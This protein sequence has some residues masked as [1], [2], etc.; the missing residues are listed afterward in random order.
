MELQEGSFTLGPKT[1]I[2]V[3]AKSR[4]V[5]EYLAEFLRVPTG[6]AFEVRQA[7]TSSDT[8]DRI[9]LRTV[10]EKQLGPEGYKLTVLAD[11]LLIEAPAEAGVFYGTQ[12]LRQLLPAAVES[13]N[14]TVGVTWKVPC[15]RIEDKPRYRWRG[16]MLDPGH[17]FLDKEITKRY[18]DTMACYKMNRLHW[19]LTDMGWAIEIKKYPELTDLANRTPIT[20]RWRRAYGKC[21]HGFYTQDDVRELV[22]YAARRQVTIIPEIEM[23][24][25]S[26]AA[27][28]CY[29]EPG[30]PQ[31]ENEDPAREEDLQQLSRELLCGQREDV[32]VSR[33]RSVGSY[34]VVP[35]GSNTYRWRRA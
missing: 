12:T 14:P 30:L 23:P 22:A 29:P 6:F 15:L 27:L 17:N 16:I 21:T 34:R 4:Q 2:V 19:H 3:D 25:H 20:N 7:T 11:R 10:D 9:I 1:E 26:T 32:R 24:G 33:G 31:L 5:G 18:I 35:V 28:A 13:R 8:A